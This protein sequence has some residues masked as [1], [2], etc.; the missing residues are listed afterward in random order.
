MGLEQ[1]KLDKLEKLDKRDID[2]FFLL[3]ILGTDPVLIIIP[4]MIISILHTTI[5]FIMVFS[6]EHYHYIA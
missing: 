6:S 1:D 5:T 4:G 2:L 3:Y